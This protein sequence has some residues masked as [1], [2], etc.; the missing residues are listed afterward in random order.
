MDVLLWVQ[1]VVPWGS[2]SHMLMIEWWLN[3]RCVL[4]KDSEVH[5]T[6]SDLLLDCEPSE[7]DFLHCVPGLVQLAVYLKYQ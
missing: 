6:I 7:D 1:K 5:E 4:I 2:G 3:G